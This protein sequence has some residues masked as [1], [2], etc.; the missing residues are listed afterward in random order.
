MNA[1]NDSL[2]RRNNLRKLI[3]KHGTV[4]LAGL[5]GH[6]NASYLSQL[7]GPHPSRD[8][9]YKAARKIEEKLH[10]ARGCLDVPTGP[11]EDIA[12]T[13]PDAAIKAP[14]PGGGLAVD[15]MRMTVCIDLVGQAIAAAGVNPTTAKIAN[16]IA[17]AYQSNHDPD[18]LPE[19]I[20]HIVS[21]LS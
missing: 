12:K 5:L 10:L 18:A 9:T 21:L 7:A 1:T 8:I 3:D 2:I 6:A 13:V 19:Y 20:R 4:T 15:V 14:L 11:L 17:I 16:V